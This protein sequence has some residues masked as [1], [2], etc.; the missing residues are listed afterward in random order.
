VKKIGID[1]DFPYFPVSV[2]LMS[3]M[4]IT[5]R[6]RKIWI[7]EAGDLIFGEAICWTPTENGGAKD[8]EWK[9]FS[10]ITAQA[11]A[12]YKIIHDRT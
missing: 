6:S 2:I 4:E 12:S 10:R 11:L 9:E 7:S 8:V 1:R 3:G 5:I